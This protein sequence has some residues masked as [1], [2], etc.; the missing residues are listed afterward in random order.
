MATE[1]LFGFRPVSLRTGKW[2]S[3]S[4]KVGRVPESEKKEE[5]NVVAK[6]HSPQ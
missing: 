3:Q 2:V 4:V 6:N 5:Y 1:G